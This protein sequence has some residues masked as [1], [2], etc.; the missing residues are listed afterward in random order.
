[1]YKLIGKFSEDN[2]GPERETLGEFIKE[3]GL[4][5]SLSDDVGDIHLYYDNNGNTYAIAKDSEEYYGYNEERQCKYFVQP[6]GCSKDNDHNELG[7]CIY[8]NGVLSY[9]SSIHCSEGKKLLTRLK[10][11]E[12]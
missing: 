4:I 7:E 6:N 11:E 12:V 2:D 9:K 8:R 1:M 3:L 10:K 5:G